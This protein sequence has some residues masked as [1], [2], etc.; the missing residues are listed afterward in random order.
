M[1]VCSW[2]MGGG[3]WASATL[4]LEVRFVMLAMLASEGS[5]REEPSD[6]KAPR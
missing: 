6:A 5:E 2:T 1:S 3:G 4:S